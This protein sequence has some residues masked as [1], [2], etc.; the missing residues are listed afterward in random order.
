[1]IT[2][3]RKGHVKLFTLSIVQN[4]LR[5]TLIFMLQYL[6]VRFQALSG[7]YIFVNTRNVQ[8]K[9]ILTSVSIGLWLA[10]CA[11]DRKHP[12]SNPTTF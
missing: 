7:E 4:S 6:N 2:T 12:G 5:I 9:L 1:M 8:S 11:P 10:Y 3:Q